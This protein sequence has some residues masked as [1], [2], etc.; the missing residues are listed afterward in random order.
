M[1]FVKVEESKSACLNQRG[2]VLAETN[3]VLL[4]YFRRRVSFTSHHEGRGDCG[5]PT[6]KNQVDFESREMRVET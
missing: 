4:L 6:Y 5:V 2:T 3:I 1:S